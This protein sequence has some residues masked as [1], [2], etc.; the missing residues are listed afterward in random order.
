MYKLSGWTQD[1]REVKR[2]SMFEHRSSGNQQ[3]EDQE[4]D[5]GTGLRLL[6]S[7]DSGRTYRVARTDDDEQY[8]IINVFVLQFYYEYCFVGIKFENGFFF[9]LSKLQLYYFV[10]VARVAHLTSVAMCTTIL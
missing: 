4:A 3:T 2:P 7:G 10:F 5:R 9:L 6:E 8:N 1:Q